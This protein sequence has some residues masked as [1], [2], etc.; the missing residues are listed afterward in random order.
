MC[1][2]KH[3][4]IIFNFFYIKIY[5]SCKNFTLFR[6][7][8]NVFYIIEIPLSC[9]FV[10]LTFLPLPNPFPGETPVRE[11]VL[12]YSARFP[13]NKM[14]FGDLKK[15]EGLSVLN[16]YLADKSYI[17]GLVYFYSFFHFELNIF[18][19]KGDGVALYSSCSVSKQKQHYFRHVCDTLEIFLPKTSYRFKIL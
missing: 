1:N 12:L 9:G 2:K 19:R 15:K 13:L 3:Q 8:I 7:L 14:G 6:K 16:A 10:I 5:I 17:E 4:K 18:E 11:H